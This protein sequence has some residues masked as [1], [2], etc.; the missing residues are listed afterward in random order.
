MDYSEENVDFVDDKL[1]KTLKIISCLKHELFPC[2][3]SNEAS[4]R[5]LY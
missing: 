1:V 2:Y 3:F 4:K 5:E